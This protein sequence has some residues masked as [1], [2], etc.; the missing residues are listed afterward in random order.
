M[1]ANG[2]IQENGPIVRKENDEI[3]LQG[4]FQNLLHVNF[5]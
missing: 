3:R 1:K 4:D 2:R 5:L